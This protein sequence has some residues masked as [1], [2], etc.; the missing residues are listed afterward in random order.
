MPSNFAPSELSRPVAPAKH[1]R[2]AFAAVVFALVA[3]TASST[4][5]QNGPAKG[6]ENLSRMLGGAKIQ[7]LDPGTGLPLQQAGISAAIDDDVSSGWTPKVGKTLLLISLPQ[8]ADL[9]AFTVFAPGAVGSYKLHVLS[10]P[11]DA[12]AAAASG[13]A[14]ATGTL[15]DGAATGST[16]AQGQYLLVELD[17]TATAPIRSLD[18]IGVPK[19]GAENTVCVVSP[20]SGEQNAGSEGDGQVVEVNFAAEAL[21]GKVADKAD[22]GL[23][24][25][26]DGDS[27]TSG[28]IVIASDTDGKALIDLAAAV[29]VKHVSLSFSEAKGKVTFIATDPENP[30]GRVLGSAT[31]DGSSKTLTLDVPGI[32][33]QSIAILWESADGSPLVVGELGVFALARVQRE[34]VADD[35]SARFRVQA[36]TDTESPAIVRPPLDNPIPPKPPVILPPAA[37]VSA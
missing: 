35:T 1:S 30:D 17:L 26:I 9:S 14:T 6:P 34:R 36:P 27:A 11:G 33:A 24:A 25:V 19:P 5:A 18:A 32:S 10:S 12:L 4:L 15:A 37:P 28:T 2:A 31:L 20:V 22:P 21:G 16:Q 3:A 29:E 7:V 23:K 8:S 13:D